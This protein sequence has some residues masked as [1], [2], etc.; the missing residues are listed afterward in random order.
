MAL[1]KER[2]ATAARSGNSIFL[3]VGAAVRIYAG[4]LVAR[5]GSGYAV[6]GTEAAGLYALGRARTTVDN[7]SGG[8]GELRVE[9]EKG[10][11]RF[12]NA[13]GG[14][15]ITP[16]DIGNDCYI[17]DDETVARSDGGGARSVAARVFDVDNMGVWLDLR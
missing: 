6:P 7:S 9:I 11:F 4:A 1:T 2:P 5:N 10:I 13:A 3:P 16:A 17:V 8:D 12:A 14:D 15:E